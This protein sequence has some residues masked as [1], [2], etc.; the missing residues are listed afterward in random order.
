MKKLFIL[1]TAFMAENSKT[2]G[3]EPQKPITRPFRVYC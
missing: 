3:L 1:L 2:A